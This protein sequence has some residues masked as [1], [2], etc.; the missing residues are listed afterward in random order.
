[1][2]LHTFRLQLL[3]VCSCQRTFLPGQGIRK[4]PFRLLVLKWN[5]LTITLA[6]NLIRVWFI[7]IGGLKKTLNMWFQKLSGVMIHVAA[8]VPHLT[9]V[10]IRCCRV[11][12]HCWTYYFLLQVKQRAEAKGEIQELTSLHKLIEYWYQLIL[13]DI[14][15]P[16][17]ISLLWK[18]CCQCNWCGLISLLQLYNWH[19]HLLRLLCLFWRFSKGGQAMRRTCPVSLFTPLSQT[20]H[21]LSACTSLH[22]PKSQG[23]TCL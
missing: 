7:S 15:I 8:F 5:I 19:T 21:L 3:V 9:I 11:I 14:Y 17:Y 20:S 2:W 13:I 1:M 6:D 10:V 12:S 22:P 18:V 23:T 4:C 16:Y